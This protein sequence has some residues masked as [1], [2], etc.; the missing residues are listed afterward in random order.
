MLEEG[1]V[2]FDI[3]KHERIKDTSRFSTKIL[4]PGCG[5]ECSGSSDSK[6][7]AAGFSRGCF[8]WVPL[9]PFVTERQVD[10]GH[11]LHPGSPQYF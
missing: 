10:R 8:Y 5:E 4:P 7:R 6:K 1:R 3:N 11:L 2:D 9:T